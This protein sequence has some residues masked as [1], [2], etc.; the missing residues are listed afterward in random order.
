M[1]EY[2]VD[3][4][5]YVRVLWR[6]K[7]AVIG[8]FI[9]AVGLTALL[10]IRA[11]AA[12]KAEATLELVPIVGWPEPIEA[13]SLEQL[14]H[15]VSDMQVLT[16]AAEGAP[17][18]A[19]WLAAHL[20]ASVS[21]D[22]LALTLQGELPSTE[23]EETLL[24]TIAALEEEVQALL[25]GV[26]LRRLEALIVEKATLRQRHAAWEAELTAAHTGE[27][28][29]LEELNDRLAELQADEGLLAT[30]LGEGMSVHS[31]LAMKELDLL[32]GRIERVE[33]ALQD[34]DRLGVLYLPGVSGAWREVEGRLMALE[35]EEAV[36]RTLIAEPP[37]LIEI[38]RS[39][40]GAVTTL[41]PSLRLNLAV[42]GVLGLFVGV[43]LA[44]F[45]ESMTRDRRAPEG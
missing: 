9:M 34:M 36:L 23:I 38:V 1:D 37:A 11:P 20:R 7:W 35:A 42:A 30:P 12:Y 6:W 31:Y 28:A 29:R 5:D 39:P 15:R 44:F 19:R 16:R 33:Q 22:T 8:V 43:L 41:R 27:K 45:V 25:T 3:L 17:I 14:A 21:R 13:P 18:S 4:R 10:T 40:V 24:G 26:A 32:F 2:E